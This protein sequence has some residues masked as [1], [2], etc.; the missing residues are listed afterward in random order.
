MV[1]C[2]F[3][4]ILFTEWIHYCFTSLSSKKILNKSTS[5]MLGCYIQHHF[6]NAVKCQT[7]FRSMQRCYIWEKNRVDCLH[8]GFFLH[9]LQVVS[10]RDKFRNTHTHKKYKTKLNKTKP[11]QNKKEQSKRFNPLTPKISSIILLL[12]NFYDVSSE[13]LELRLINNS[14][15]YIFLYS[16]HLSAWFCIDIVRRNITLITY[17]IK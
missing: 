14:L 17:G 11:N 10:V 4:L 16:H 6:Q 5:L 12:Y 2:F 8:F 7:R 3:K 13:N 15:I 1:S 9:H